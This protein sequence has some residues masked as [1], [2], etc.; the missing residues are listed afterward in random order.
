M[1]ASQS[2]RRILSNYQILIAKLVG[3]T[4]ILIEDQ[5]WNALL[6]LEVPLAG[7]KPIEVE[8]FIYNSCPAFIT[9]APNNQHFTKLVVCVLDILQV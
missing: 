3:P 2:S 8:N 1:G 7:L 4:C 5:F 6:S 9:N